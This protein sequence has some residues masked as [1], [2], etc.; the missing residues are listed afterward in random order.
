MNFF[1][2][3]FVFSNS[4]KKGIIWFAILLLLLCGFYWVMPY[5]FNP[6]PYDFSQKELQFISE[7]KQES[8]VKSIPE[9]FAF[10]PNTIS[11]DSLLLLGLST[12]QA[13]NI[14]NYRK[15][16]SKFNTKSDFSKI[17]SI[18]DSTYNQLKSYLVLPNSQKVTPI[19]I[20]VDDKVKPEIKKELFYFDPNYINK[21]D[22][23]KLGFSDKE[24]NTF[25][26]F[27]NKGG[28][29]FKKEDVKKVYS[30]TN[31][32][33]TEIEPFIKFK[34][35]E[36]NNSSGESIVVKLNSDKAYQLEKGLDVS[37]KISYRILNYRTKLGGFHSI[38]Q[39]YEV[40]GLDSLQII[41]M[42]DKIVLDKIDLIKVKINSATF[43]ELVNHPYLSFSDVK[44]IVNYRQMHGKFSTL[45]QILENNLINPK[46][47]RKIVPYLTLE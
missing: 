33:Y 5:V 4:E 41:K 34:E 42:K 40:Y 32:L 44:K 3:Y 31:K 27:R 35:E 15:K 39:L 24:A 18:P 1:D 37:K 14:I 23:A 8:D 13:Y 2:D 25:M 9:L 20:K 12:K 26:N 46:Q 7:V 11:K 43:K 19:N 28:K 21:K 10:N 22:L 29:F 16:V 30:V 38:S 45:E 47:Y 17:Y 36:K 6:E